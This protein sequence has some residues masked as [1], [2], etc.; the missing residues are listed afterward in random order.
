MRVLPGELRDD[1]RRGLGPQVC[2]VC[3]RGA[4]A[5]L[6]AMLAHG[7][8]PLVAETGARAITRRAA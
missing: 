7:G 4:K 6:E 2:V 8:L 3:D 1:I 5:K